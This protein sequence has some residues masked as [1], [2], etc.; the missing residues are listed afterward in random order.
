MQSQSSQ[1][2][3]CQYSKIFTTMQKERY[4]HID[5]TLINS[6]TMEIHCAHVEDVLGRMLKYNVKPK[7][8]KC[9]WGV[10]RLKWCGRYIS[11]AG[12]E[13]DKSVVKVLKEFKRPA[14]WSQV[15]TLVGFLAWHKNWVPDFA[16]KCKPITKFLRVEWKHKR[17][18]WFEDPKTEKAY[19]EIVN[20]IE[21]AVA[22]A[23]SG[24]GE[25][26][27]YADWSQEAIGYHLVRTHKGKTYLMGY[28]GRTLRDAETR[29]PPPR[30]ELLAMAQA[31]TPVSQRNMLAC[32]A[33]MLLNG[34][35]TWRQIKSTQNLKM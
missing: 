33:G 9:V 3:Q 16:R 15:Q 4:F 7:W 12:V 13:V 31:C 26:H 29:Y 18:P 14:K 34:L 10:P 19:V 8:R 27:I 24:P 23:R 1:T 5:D 28:G 32:R 25:M 6:K 35:Q 22:R 30:G 21:S 17:I 20:D 11:A 2:I